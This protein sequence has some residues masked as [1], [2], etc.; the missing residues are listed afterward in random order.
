M[1]NFFWKNLFRQEEDCSFHV[2][3][4]CEVL[5]KR[6]ERKEDLKDVVTDKK[7]E[8]KMGQRKRNGFVF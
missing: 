5:V 3:D 4:A 8:R 1:E 7:R 2:S 6:M